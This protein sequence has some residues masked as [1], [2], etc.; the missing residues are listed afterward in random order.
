MENIDNQN[1]ALG[2]KITYLINLNIFGRN[3]ERFCN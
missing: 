3:D 2:I 1:A